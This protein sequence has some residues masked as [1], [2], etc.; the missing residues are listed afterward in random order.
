MEIAGINLEEQI[1]DRYGNCRDQ[2]GGEV[3]TVR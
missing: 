3:F 2:F 1:E